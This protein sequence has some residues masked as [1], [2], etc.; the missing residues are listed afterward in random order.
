MNILLPAARGDLVARTVA[1][2]RALRRAGAVAGPGESAT[3]VAALRSVD[4]GDRR[5]VYWGLRTAL[6][7]RQEDVA[8]FDAL[9]DVYFGPRQPGEDEADDAQAA[10]Q[11]PPAPRQT[12][13][14][15]SGDEGEG[16]DGEEAG[17][18][19][20]TGYSPAERLATRDFATLDPSELEEMAEIVARLARRLATRL[21]RRLRTARRRGP[22]DLRRAMRRSL[23]HGGLILTLPRRARRVARM[24]I[25]VLCDVSGSMDRYSRLLLQFLYALQARAWS[26]QTFLFSTRLTR[27]TAELALPDFLAAAQ[28]AG[29]RHPG[30]SGGTQIGKCLLRFVE[31]EGR[32]LLSRRT[33]V[34]ILSDGWD[35]GEP[36][37]LAA[38]M[39][40][41]RERCGRIVWLNPLLGTPG[42]QP[43]TLGM[44]TA[45]P[46]CD[47]FAPAHSLEA[48]RRLE[49]H[50]DLRA[51]IRG[52]A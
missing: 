48:L 36:A 38:A 35:T 49:R 16:D 1:F 21:S 42:Y 24:R 52:G 47:V 26:V 27:V 43:L 37:L 29:G 8:A 14:L 50:L 18:A 46:Y 13:D 44:S 41:L 22:I 28:A 2:A 4:L 30:W 32:A 51:G 9:F 34:V 15:T 40:R 12:V 10:S 45:L 39:R 7:R 17:G 19:L 20:R 6:V 23:R 25:A 11:E 3:A 33:V 5:D 31:H